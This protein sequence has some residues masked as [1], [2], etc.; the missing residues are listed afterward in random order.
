MKRI[1]V[2]AALIVAMLAVPAAAMA[3]TASSGSGS[4]HPGQ[5][6]F[7]PN[8]PF[9]QHRH[10]HFRHH[11]R[12]HG[13]HHRH[14]NF[15]NCFPFFPPV[16]PAGSCTGPSFIFTWAHNSNSF[17]EESGPTLAAG[18]QFSFDGNIFTIGTANPAAG[19]YTLT[20]V[21]NGPSII[22]GVANVC[23]SSTY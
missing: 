21:N 12:D 22:F 19:S 23:S 4:G 20:T 15:N 10:H 7:C 9:F 16:P 8:N 6:Q 13:R 17:F 11:F 5:G 2:M 18:E 1:A 3:A 14:H